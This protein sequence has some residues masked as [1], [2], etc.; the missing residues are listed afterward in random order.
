MCLLVVF[1]TDY[2]MIFFGRFTSIKGA[3]TKSSKLRKSISASHKC[4]A[5]PP[6]TAGIEPATRSGVVNSPLFL[7]TLGSR[8]TRNGNIF[9][10][11]FTSIKVLVFSLKCSKINVIVWSGYN[12]ITMTF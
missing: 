12:N 6:C 9:L 5:I 2:G 4:Y 8:Y 1:D 7:Y 10:S 3:C 11:D